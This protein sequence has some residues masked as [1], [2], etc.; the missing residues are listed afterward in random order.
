MTYRVTKTTDGQ[1]LG[2]VVETVE[3]GNIVTFE[4][5]DV[6]SIDEVFSKDEGMTLIAVSANY[7][8]TLT[9]E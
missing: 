5:G 6:I 7:Q 4:D 8:M 1:H 2:A 9:K 3:A